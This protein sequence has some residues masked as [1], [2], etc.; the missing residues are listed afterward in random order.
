MR[1]NLD[2]NEFLDF[3]SIIFFDLLRDEGLLNDNDR[4]NVLR[5]ELEGRGVKSALFKYYL[6]APGEIRKEYKTR[7]KPMMVD[8]SM[9]TNTLFV[10]PYIE[11]LIKEVAR[12]LLEEKWMNKKWIR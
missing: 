4:F 12:L 7:F 2:Y 11:Q 10:F 3:I 5:K 9:K 1:F 8:G 6:A